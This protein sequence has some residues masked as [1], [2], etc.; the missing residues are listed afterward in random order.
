MAS[1]SAAPS[2]ASRTCVRSISPATRNQLLREG[3]GE[4]RAPPRSSVAPVEVA[5]AI[6]LPEAGILDRSCGRGSI[7]RGR[8]T[9]PGQ[10]RNSARAR[11]VALRGEVRLH[12]VHRLLEARLLLGLEQRMVLERIVG[13][14]TVDRHL[15]VEIRILL[16][17]I[18]V[19]PDHLREQRRG[20]Y[21][22]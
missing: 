1:E 19:I 21:R 20:L 17:Q 9:G 5:G 12:A 11:A 4:A 22:H 2:P 3:A 7:L 14:V 13:P 16:L 15:P 8:L 18:E 6:D 10:V